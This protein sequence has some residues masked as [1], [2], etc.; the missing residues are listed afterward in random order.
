MYT[1]NI[2][3]GKSGQAD[4]DHFTLSYGEGRGNTRQV[5]Y[6]QFT[7][8]VQKREFFLYITDQYYGKIIG[9]ILADNTYKEV[10]VHTGQC[11]CEWNFT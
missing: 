8:V 9:H 6:P 7:S 1:K 10:L 4:T 3:E 5:L 2:W 11:K